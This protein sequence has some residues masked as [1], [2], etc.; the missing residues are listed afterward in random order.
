MTSREIYLVQ[1]SWQKVLPIADQAAEMFYGRL[2]EIAP[3]VG[4]LFKG[5][6]NAQG[7]KLMGM[8]NTAVDG[9]AELDRIVP[10]VKDLG[11]R[12]SGYGVTDA[13][14]ESVGEALIWTLQQGLGKAFTAEVREAWISTYTLL[15]ETMKNGVAST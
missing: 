10:S 8:I 2:F 3:Q 7:R 15:A 12:H 14:Y 4:T 5:D 13:H 9:L 11:R 6:M 1:S